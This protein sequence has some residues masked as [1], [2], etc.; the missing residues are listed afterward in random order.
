M[1][2]NVSSCGVLVL[3]LCS[4]S[5]SCTRDGAPHMIDAGGYRV[6]AVIR[7]HGGPAVVFLNSGFGAALEGWNQIQPKVSQFT[8]SMAYDRGGTYK[9]EPA[10]LPRDS[11]HIAAELH[12]VLEHAGVKTPCVLV[13]ASL[14]G[15]HARIFAHSY[16]GDVAGIVLVDPTAEDLYAKVQAQ[17][18][19]E[20]QRM[21]MQRV[22]MDRE[23][24]GW[25]QGARSEYQSLAINFQQAR[26]SWPLPPV[27]VILLTSMRT[28][29]AAGAR[30]AAIKLELHREFLKRVPGAKQIVTNE[31]GHNIAMEE[32]GL[33]VSAIREIVEAQRSRMR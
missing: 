22:E 16:P 30:L 27:P 31:S 4:G 21:D 17:E 32:P 20:R 10:P 9:S 14:G 13:G 23:A 19:V 15:I 12:S 2:L 26:E 7:G 28:D 3:V 33:V 25:D 5:I 24:S 6:R 8:R 18:P 1:H 11:A 29:S